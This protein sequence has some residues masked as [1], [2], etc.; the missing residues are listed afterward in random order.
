MTHMGFV[1]G[2]FY[3]TALGR[4]KSRYISKTSPETCFFLHILSEN[5]VTKSRQHVQYVPHRN[6]SQNLQS[7]N[8]P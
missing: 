6:F 4:G 3:F 1:S 5:Y 7:Q 8:L 2:F